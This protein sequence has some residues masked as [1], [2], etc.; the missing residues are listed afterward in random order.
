MTSTRRAKLQDEVANIKAV[1]LR[2][3]VLAGIVAGQGR[4]DGAGA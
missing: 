3:D 1:V 2:F 4:A